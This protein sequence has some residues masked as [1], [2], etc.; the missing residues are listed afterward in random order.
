VTKS[1][2]EKRKLVR[3]WKAGEREAAEKVLPAPKELLLK[4][5]DHL[6]EKLA[7]EGCDHTLRLTIA[8]AKAQGLDSERIAAWTHENGGFCDCEVL[9]NVESNNPAFGGI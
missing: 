1:K 4:L 5:L 7:H 6:D 8:W 9:A 2:D 3:A